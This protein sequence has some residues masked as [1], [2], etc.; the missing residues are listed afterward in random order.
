MKK[1][2]KSK[3]TD[4][5]KKAEELL[6]KRSLET[7]SLI[8]S[9]VETLKLLHELEVH[10]IEL[11]M[12]NEELI[13][14][15]KQAEACSKK[16]TELYD[17]APTGYFTL[18]KGGKIIELNLCGANLLGKERQVLKNSMFNY[19]V[20]EYSW[21]IFNLFLTKVFNRQFVK[22]CEV[23]LS[24]YDNSLK[25]VYLTGLLA[26]DGEHCLV[27]VVDITERRSAE[28]K[29]KKISDE[30]IIADNKIAIQSR[31]KEKR[32]TEIIIGNTEQEYF[33]FADR[34]VRQL[35][36]IASHELQQPISA[37]TDYI[38]ILDKECG[39]LL[40]VNAH[41]YLLSIKDAAAKP[42]LIINSLLNFS[43]LGLN[44]KLTYC[45]CTQLIDN[46]ITDLKSIIAISY[47]AIEVGDM[48]KLNLYETEI[49]QLFRNLILNAIRSRKKDRQ[50]QIKINSGKTEDYYRF[51]ISDNGTGIAPDRLE[52]IFDVFQ[53]LNNH[54]ELEGSRIRL[55]LCK[56]IVK[57]HNGEIWVEP[58]TDNGSTF[59]FTIATLT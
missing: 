41:K 31:E 1:N 12:Q 2:I 20:S 56:K 46:V 44:K 36:Y 9:E 25:H 40:D 48:P 50:L 30:L 49:S 24:T 37:V 45:D 59:F 26:E 16:Y 39:E 4:L 34:E 22:S 6:L 23:I 14:A 3:I 35:A 19:F 8:H 57:Q 17:F 18:S 27:N 13:L 28:E 29:L 58:D 7:P 51:S 42:A 11:E 15:K 54:E 52:N 10:Q 47:A 53:L 32:D 43:R 38:N 55:A 33:S 5:R 21:P